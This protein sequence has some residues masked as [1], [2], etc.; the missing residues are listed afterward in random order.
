MVWSDIFWYGDIHVWAKKKKIIFKIVCTKYMGNC[1]AMRSST[2]SFAYSYRLFKKCFWWKL[3][4][5]KISYLPYLLS[6]LKHQMFTVIFEM[7]YSF[8]WNNL[9][10]NRVSPLIYRC[11]LCLKILRLTTV[12]TWWI[13]TL[14][15]VLVFTRWT[16]R[17]DRPMK[18]PVIY[19]RFIRRYLTLKVYI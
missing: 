19:S 18:I 16:S 9:N 12:T 2:H 3:Q 11:M 15:S 6:H 7:F 1:E 10:L 13:L 17:L 4:K 5:F 14:Y 8:S